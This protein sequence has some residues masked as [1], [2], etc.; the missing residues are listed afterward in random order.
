MSRLTVFTKDKQESVKEQLYRDLERRII[1]SPTGLCPVDLTNSFIRL[2][3]SQSCGKCTP[4]RVGLN[5]LS[6]LL[7]NVLDG[8]ANLDT[9]ELIKKTAETIYLSS[10]CAIGQEAGKLALNSI[11]ECYDDYKEHVEN[12]NCTCNS[13]NPVSCVNMCPAHVDIPGYIAL[14]K[15]GRYD[16]AVNLVRHMN[17]FPI[18]CAYICEHPCED[19]CKRNIVDAPVNIR[20]IKRVAIEKSNNPSLPKKAEKTGKK[21]AIIGGGPSGLSCAYYLQLMGHE[22]TVYEQRKQLGGMLRYG[23]PSYRFPR[24]K[25]DEE[26]KFILSTGIK[27]ELEKSIGKDIEFS[28]IKNKF[29]AIYIAIGAHEDKK[30]GIDGEDAKNVISAVEMLREIGDGNITSYKDKRVV[31]VGGGNV[32]MDV[33]RSS[34]RLGAKSVDIVYRR[35]KV[36]MTALPEEVEGAEAE[37]CDV[38]ELMSPVAIEKNADGSVKALKVKPQMTSIIESKRPSPKDK[39]TDEVSIPCD[40][41]VVSIGQGIDSKHFEDKGIA[42]KRGN[43]STFDSGAVGDMA[44]VFAGGDCVSGPATVIRAIAAGRVAAANIDEYLGFNHEIVND[45]SIPEVSFDDKVPCGRVELSLRK[46]QDRKDDFEAIENT[47]SDEE[48]SQECGRCLRCD[49]F[50]FGAIRGGRSTKW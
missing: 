2:C 42:V 46:A 15:E 41:L 22:V 39:N 49:H 43:I 6:E 21:I 34:I 11:T 24:E 48:C 47:M 45:I 27:V 31:V 38:V 50:G 44:G 35:R 26:I 29:D 20:G 33:A 25:L 37:G 16:D 32:A 13:N 18:T 30:I 23:I 1:A 12:N 4:C 19:R 17:P 14:V 8:E 5:K 10:D 3:L 28:D 36:D 40:I 9:L 7:E